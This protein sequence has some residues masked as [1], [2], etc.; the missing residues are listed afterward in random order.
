[1]FDGDEAGLKASYKSA[2]MAL[3]HLSPNKYLQFI[4]L[5][6]I[7]IQIVYINKLFFIRNLL[8]FKKTNIN[9]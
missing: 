9:C 2:L 3:P 8:N 6:K 5:P 1:M 4:K 7:M